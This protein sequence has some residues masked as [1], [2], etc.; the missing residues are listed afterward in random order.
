MPYGRTSDSQPARAQPHYLLGNTANMLVII[1]SGH[2]D[3]HHQVS[4]PS[5]RT[6][7]AAEKRRIE[8]EATVAAAAAAAN[9]F[10]LNWISRIDNAC[11]L[12][13]CTQWRSNHSNDGDDEEEGG[14]RSRKAASGARAS[15]SLFRTVRTTI[16][17]AFCG[18][19]WRIS[20]LAMW[21]VRRAFFSFFVCVSLRRRDPVE[22]LFP[23][24]SPD[25]KT[26]WHLYPLLAT[27]TISLRPHD[28]Q[29]TVG[30]HLLLTIKWWEQ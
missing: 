19:S 24:L 17:S 16:N 22:T 29:W 14:E 26:N 13:A 10:N 7:R 21:R 27:S 28:I 23:S 8:T 18:A 1:P 30:H 6:T 25:L 20:M 4:A 9:S 3:H 11:V 15:A 5:T 12:G 2:L